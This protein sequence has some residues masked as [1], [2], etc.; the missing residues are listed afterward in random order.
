MWAGSPTGTSSAVRMVVT[1]ADARVPAW[2]ARAIEHLREVAGLAVRVVALPGCAAA[3]PSG[4]LAALA[5]AAMRPRVVPLD[6]GGVD[7]ADIV[8]NLSGAPLSSAG[9]YE[10]WSL[11]ADDER[12][13]PF[14]GEIAAGS[15]T[16]SIALVREGAGRRECLRAGRF[17]VT[18]WYGATLKRALFEA[19]R[20]PAVFAGALLSGIALADAPPVDRRAAAP[21]ANR[22]RFAGMLAVR[23]LRA[24]VETAFEITEWNVG[25]APGDA[26]TIVSGEPL[27]VRWLP[28]P[29]ARSFLADPFLVERDGRRVLFAEDYTYE[30]DRGVLDALELDGDGRVLA[31]HR[32]LD[33]PTH[34]S[35][36]F[37]LEIDGTLYLVP[38]NCAGNEVALYRCVE[39]PARWE[40]EAAIF[41]DFDGVD[42]TLFS[43]DGR[44]WAF[45]TRYSHGSM[46]SLY[47]F[48]G[49]S[50]RGPWTPHALN[51]IV[52]D[53]ASARPA[54]APFVVDGVLY[55]P[56]QDC[57]VTYGGAVVV[58]RVDELSPHAYR[59]TIV[60][61]IDGSSVPSPYCDGVH[62]LTFA[63]GTIVLD[64][65]RVYHDVRKLAW[66]LQKASVKLRGRTKRAAR[67]LAGRAAKASLLKRV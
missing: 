30:R 58:A 23:V 21:A 59:E 18:R 52:V 3:A 37:P 42:T 11:G 50:P 67:S 66:V 36:P 63:P 46:Q 35:Y 2:H 7:D 41:P 29:R 51:P 39:F 60:R 4:P 10:L 62:T 9:T 47:A 48:H 33:L 40:R 38:E 22:V 13:L 12:G 28:R 65:K 26:R 54:G 64:G 17:A 1:V 24:V 53:V 25:L 56:A 8:L 16:V 15:D 14:E 31:R 57:S 49:D 32:V 6:A 45:C 5:G 43:H 19:A 20:W 34:L 61:R 55:R 44:W 27:D